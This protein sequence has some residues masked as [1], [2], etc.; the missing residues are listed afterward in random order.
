MTAL[1]W[2]VALLVITVVLL[3]VFLAVSVRRSPDGE[4]TLFGHPVYSV[5]SGSME[6]TFYTGDLIVDQPVSATAARHLHKGQ[7]ITFQAAAA[8]GTA[9][10]LVITHRIYAVVPGQL[11]AG[12]PTVEYRTKGD[13]NNAPDATLVAPSAILGLYQGQRIPFGGYVLSALHQPITFVVLIMI[14]TVYVAE[15]L[16]RRQW[17]ALGEREAERRRARADHQGDA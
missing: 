14:V 7:I 11:V 6:P 5:D 10:G 9:P 3:A 1:R 16:I 15:E 17:V 12:V 2:V 8:A 13:A 4:T